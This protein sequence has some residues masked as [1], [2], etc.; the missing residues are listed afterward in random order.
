MTPEWIARQ[1]VG[2]VIRGAGYRATSKLSPQQA[3]AFLV[4]VAVLTLIFAL[5]AH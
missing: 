3:L 1:V 4:V 5:V 2:S